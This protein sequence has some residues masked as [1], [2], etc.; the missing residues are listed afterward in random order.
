MEAVGEGGA[1]ALDVDL[2]IEESAEAVAAP[3][4][5]EV[6]SSPGP[7]SPPRPTA[8]SCARC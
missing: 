5:V 8:C 4:G 3:D 1:E 6:R 7:A 2:V